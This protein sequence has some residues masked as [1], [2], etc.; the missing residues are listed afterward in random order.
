M[1]T[2][3]SKPNCQAC[4]ATKTWFTRNGLEFKEIDVTEDEAAEQLCKKLGYL[5]LPVVVVE[6]M[7]GPNSL[8][9]SGFR[10][11]NM[12]LAKQLTMFPGDAQ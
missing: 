12:I 8:H 7:D 2:V 9:W 11:S 3:Y 1:I 10:Y 6:N 5:E 4:N